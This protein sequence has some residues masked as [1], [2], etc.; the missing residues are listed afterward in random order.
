MG[1]IREC[2]KSRY[3]IRKAIRI[4]NKMEYVMLHI[5]IMTTRLYNMYSV[6]VLCII[7]TK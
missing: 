6:Y 4:G 5:F 7:I 2:F 3:N 1:E